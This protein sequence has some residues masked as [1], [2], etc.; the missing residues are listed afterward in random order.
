MTIKPLIWR[1][2][3]SPHWSVYHGRC[4]DREVCQITQ[5]GSAWWLSF[6]GSRACLIYD[7]LEAAQQAAQTEWQAFVLSSLEP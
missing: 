6:Y 7:T 5:Q 3:S 2:S 1:D 4:G